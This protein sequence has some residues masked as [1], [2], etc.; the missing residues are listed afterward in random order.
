MPLW[1]PACAGMTGGGGNDGWAGMTGGGGNP[2]PPSRSPCQRRNCAVRLFYHL[3]SSPLDSRLRGNDGCGGHDGKCGGNT[4]KNPALWIPA[5]AGMTESVAGMTE[6]VAGIQ[7][8][9]VIPA[10]AG[11]QNPPVIPAQAGIQ[12]P[13]SQSPRRRESRTPPRHSR[14]GENPEPPRHSRAGGN[15]EPPRHSRAGGNPEPP[16]SFPRRRESRTPPRGSPRKAGI[17]DSPRIH[18]GPRRRESR[19]PPVGMTSD[20]VQRVWQSQGKLLRGL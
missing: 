13:P 16:P 12:N 1:I 3:E 6:S 18:T 20:L 4:H 11:I 17:Q 15:P 8:P 7:N 5:C 19:T 9:P 14:A 10:Q 2:E